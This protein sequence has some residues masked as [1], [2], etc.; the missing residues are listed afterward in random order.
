MAWRQ[1]LVEM[2]V[3]RSA[4]SRRVRQLAR[5]LT[6]YGFDWD[7]AY[8][9]SLDAPRGEN[10]EEYRLVVLRGRLEEGREPELQARPDI[11]HIWSDAPIA[12]LAEYVRQKE[13]GD[14]PA[15]SPFVF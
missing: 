14:Q 15:R 13:E 4:S 12:P 11:I 6:D 3:P 1:V 9:V 8:L 2:Q 7:P 10:S 5:R